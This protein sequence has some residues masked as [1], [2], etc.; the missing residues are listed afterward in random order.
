MLA[1]KYR[2]DNFELD[3]SKRR[4]L[5]DG[6]LIALNPKAFE[7]LRVLIEHNGELLTKDDLMQLVWDGQFIEEANLTVNMSAIRRALGENPKTPRYITTVSGRGY[8]F[9]AEVEELDE[10]TAYVVESRT[11]SRVVLTEEAEVEDG[12]LDRAQLPPVRTQRRAVVFSSVFFFALLAGAVVWFLWASR[13]A[14]VPFQRMDVRRL[15]SS[16]RITTG[17]LSPDGKLYAY[18][19]QENNGLTGIW[20]EHIDGANRIELCEPGERSVASIVFTPDSGQLYYSIYGSETEQTGVYRMPVFGGAAELVR[21]GIG[22]VTFAPDGKS[23][24]FVRLDEAARTS[25]VRISDL[26]GSEFV[27]TERSSALPFVASTID[28]SRDGKHIAV[29]ALKDEGTR[30]QEIFV[31]DSGG[32]ELKQL[33]SARW[34]GV[35]ALAWIPDGS[36]LIATA[37][38]QD[39][40]WEAQLWHVSTADGQSTRLISDLNTYGMVLSVAGDGRS[41]LTVQA[42]SYS[43]IWVA[44]ADNIAAARQVTF[45]MLGRQNGWDGLDWGSGQSIF[46]TSYTDRSETIWVLDL[47][48]NSS[49]Q[50]IPNGRRNTLVSLSANGR[51]MVFESNRSG[52]SE[53]WAANGDGSSMRQLT[54][55]G[56]N[57]Q[58]HV[59][60]DG[61]RVIYQSIRD[62]ASAL[63]QIATIGGEPA[64][65]ISRNIS[66]AQFSRDGEYIAGAIRDA[67]RNRLGV[68]DA[69]GGDP[70]KIFDFPPQA[71]FRLGIHWTPDG[72]GV[73]Y[74][75]WANG[76]WRQPIDG[77]PPARVE[78]LPEEKIY[79]YGWSKDGRQ[80]AYSRGMEIRDV[81]LIKEAK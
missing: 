47:N 7:M 51:T 23:Y 53:I 42:Q 43:N 31:V 74:R 52:S 1:V 64:R 61:T 45:D 50:L 24:A 49:K 72:S 11:H 4:L 65:I 12:P 14:D 33:T 56:G 60:P 59:S 39:V 55:G 77:G 79:A 9:T 34:N 75:D 10:A 35:R 2:F 76:I 25:T 73:T 29:S 5:R 18:S 54:T 3:I 22:R 30:E 46:Y 41:L 40:G 26:A 70:I 8:Y 20:L 44:P 71:N 78:G 57:F 19:Q 17:A 58:P 32:L 13:S 6:E 28:W 80:L 21:E 66:W 36:G 16:G 62:G 15:T 48:D 69:K 68:F 38:D 37:G 81:V 27:V 63:W 67:G